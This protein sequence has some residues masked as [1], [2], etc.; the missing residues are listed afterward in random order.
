[1]ESMRKAGQTLR[2]NSRKKESA[3][4]P[5][6]PPPQQQPQQPQQ[7]QQVQPPAAALPAPD[8]AA[9]TAKNY[10]MAKE[11]SELRV[12]HR[13]ECKNVSRLT[14]ENVSEAETSEFLIRNLTF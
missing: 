8:P 1:M 3:P 9:L 7:H 10:R 13:D 4:P 5:P 14:M 12:R 2:R 6:P 11:L